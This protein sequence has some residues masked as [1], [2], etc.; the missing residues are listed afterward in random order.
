[1]WLDK[2]ADQSAVGKLSEVKHEELFSKAS[3]I[4][5]AAGLVDT[6]LGT[7]EV[8]S[9]LLDLQR[10]RVRAVTAKLRRGATV[11]EAEREAESYARWL[12]DLAGVK[13]KGGAAGGMRRRD[14][15]MREAEQDAGDEAGEGSR[16]AGRQPAT[17]TTT[18]AIW[19][20]EDFD[21]DI[22]LDQ[23]SS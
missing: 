15:V 12:A 5:Y 4:A 8:G 2:A 13:P 17:D 3:G 16:T 1:T 22:D 11:T 6:V 9:Q 7:D 10:D 23:P 20:E 14:V 21:L 19:S 18:T